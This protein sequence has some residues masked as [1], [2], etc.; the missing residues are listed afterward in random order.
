MTKIESPITGEEALK[1][2]RVLVQKF[3]YLEDEAVFTRSREV[4]LDRMEIYKIIE[5]LRKIQERLEFYV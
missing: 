5:Q 1:I 4:G 2:C 3:K